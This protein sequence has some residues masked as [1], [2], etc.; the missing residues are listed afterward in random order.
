MGIRIAKTNTYITEG[1]KVGSVIL[2]K[3]NTYISE[4]PKVGVIIMTK[5]NTYISE[6]PKFVNRMRNF[7]S[8]KP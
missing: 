3:V 5:V 2:A 7:F 8:F 6:G 1:P 4:G